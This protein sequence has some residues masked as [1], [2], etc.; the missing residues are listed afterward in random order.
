MAAL[1]QNEFC[2]TEVENAVNPH[3]T[4][5]Y[6]HG[7]IPNP[8][9]GWIPPSRVG[10]TMGTVPQVS[11]AENGMGPNPGLVISKVH[12]GVCWIAVGQP[13]ADGSVAADA[14]MCGAVVNDTAGYR[15]HL[16]NTHPGATV[17]PDRRVPT[18]EERLAGKAAIT[19][20]IRSG[21]WRRA[22]FVNEPNAGP[23]NG[24]IE[25]LATGMEELAVRDAAFRA[26]YGSEFHRCV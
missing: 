26:R 11:P 13:A 21:G 19:A 14:F 22:N 12:G 9:Y 10:H 18:A 20:F 24:I 5:G 3:P 1:L 15:R 2:Y 8:N 4:K 7:P 17:N 25:L 23:S 16:R 6:F